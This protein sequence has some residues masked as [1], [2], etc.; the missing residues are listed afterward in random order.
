MGITLRFADK[1]AALEYNNTGELKNKLAAYLKA[2][3]ET[4]QHS[5]LK[6]LQSNAQDY[7]PNADTFKNPRYE[8]GSNFRHKD[9]GNALLQQ[10][11]RESE[12]HPGGMDEVDTIFLESNLKLVRFL[13][14]EL[15]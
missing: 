9:N 4:F 15:F 6:E 2:H 10:F 3:P 14:F 8:D 13:D 7:K 5:D 11:D 1:H 12:K